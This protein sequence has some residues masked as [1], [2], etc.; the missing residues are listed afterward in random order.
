MTA[1][2]SRLYPFLFA[3]VPVLHLVATNPGE[4]SLGDLLVVLLVILA[5]CALVYAAAA[6]AFRGRGSALPALVTFIG[7]LFF[8]GL[9][10]RAQVLLAPVFLVASLLL[11]RSLARRPPLLERLSGFL[12]LT[13]V[14]LVAWSAVA[15]GSSRL[16]AGESVKASAL[17]RRLARPIATTTPVGAAQ[18]RRDIFLIVLDE[19]AGSRVLREEF[20]YDNRPFEDSLRRLGFVL[21]PVV[22]SNYAHTM[23]SLP[24]LLNASHLTAA[25]SE[26]GTAG[27][28]PT[29]AGYLLDHS[30][31]IRFLQARGYRFVFFP[32]GWWFATQ[33]HPLANLKYRASTGGGLGRELTRSGLRR[34]LLRSTLLDYVYRSHA[35]DAEHVRSTLAGVARAGELQGPVFAV[36]H[37]INPH[38]PFV[39]EP[40]CRTAPWRSAGGEPGG[41]YAGQVE[42]L[43][44]LLLRLV[45]TLLRE[46][47]VAPIILLQ[48][49]HGTRTLEYASYP[50]ASSPAAAARERLSA[51]GAYYLPSGGGEAF[52]D[53]VT[54]VNVLGNVLRHYFDAD[55][56]PEP[57]DRYMSLER[58]PYAL[59][60]VDPG[61]LGGGAPAPVSAPP[62][63]TSSH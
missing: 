3:L 60:K 55:L 20:G 47:E 5:G 29:L 62:L 41:T 19:Y 63:R 43:N 14:L 52:G 31:V 54:V 39:F 4:S 53:T 12:T 46:S 6:R 10:E 50:A 15:I 22:Q 26:V 27:K 56:R 24:S 17:V 28:D 58:F 16:R 8:F 35:P 44:E 25:T 1:R 30:R 13:S 21:P 32:S 40:D 23:L 42:C 48:A 18:P 59:R 57:D 37:L 7:V 36:A 49:D 33:D 34:V 61:W 9:R 45:T 51:F 11:V 2:I 38:P